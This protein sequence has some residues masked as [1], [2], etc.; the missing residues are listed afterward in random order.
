MAL[1]FSS[2]S[3][4]EIQFRNVSPKRVGKYV[5]GSVLGRGAYGKVKE[6]Y[7]VAGNKRVAVKIVDLHRLRKIPGASANFP[8]ELLILSQLSHPNIVRL[9]DS[10][11]DP[12]RGKV[13]IILDYMALGDLEAYVEA[14]PVN[15]MLPIPQVRR[16]LKSVCS[17]VQYIHSKNVIHRDIKPSNILISAN[18]DIKLA[19]FGIAEW[20]DHPS[21]CDPCPPTISSSSMHSDS[22]EMVSSFDP[23]KR[24][25][26]AG[27]PAFQPP[28]LAALTGSSSSRPIPAHDIWAVGITFFYLLTH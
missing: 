14:L 8:H 13:F 19:D 20:C 26:L 3:D 1:S 7:T 15:Q 28:E 9:L 16:V 27:T 21:S 10:F 6:G 11:Q 25:Q 23:T 17:A 22:F 24:R 2:L 12:S 18:G 4:S 5:V